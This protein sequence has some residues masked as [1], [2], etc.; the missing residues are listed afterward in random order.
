MKELIVLLNFRSAGMTRENIQEPEE[1]EQFFVAYKL[2]YWK[3]NGS[4]PSPKLRSLNL[5]FQ[6]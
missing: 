3:L 6:C 5:I 2:F 4:T 1:F